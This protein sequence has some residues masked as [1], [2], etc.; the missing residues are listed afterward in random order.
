MG[1]WRGAATATAAEVF[2][3][4]FWSEPGGHLWRDEV[5]GGVGGRRQEPPPVISLRIEQIGWE[6]LCTSR[7][8]VSGREGREESGEAYQSLL[9]G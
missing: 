8:P 4:I 9:R 7:G 6:R 5:E 1:S 3:A 2:V